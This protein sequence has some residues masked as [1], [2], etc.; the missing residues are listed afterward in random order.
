MKIHE[1]IT[2]LK[3]LPPDIRAENDSAFKKLIGPKLTFPRGYGRT[4]RAV[5]CTERYKRALLWLGL[6][7]DMAAVDSLAREESA[8]QQLASTGG[9][10]TSEYPP[11]SPIAYLKFQ[12]L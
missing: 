9:V 10:Q 8:R 5:E 4:K 2:M 1:V 12:E 3:T 11:L 7:F 6:R